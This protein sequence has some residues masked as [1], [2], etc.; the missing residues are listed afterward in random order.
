MMCTQRGHL[1]DILKNRMNSQW[2]PSFYEV[3]KP[4]TVKEVEKQMVRKL[5]WDSKVSGTW[6]GTKAAGVQDLAPGSVAAPGALEESQISDCNSATPSPTRAGKAA[7][8]QKTPGY[9]KLLGRIKMQWEMHICGAPRCGHWLGHYQ[10]NRGT[11]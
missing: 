10:K 3:W 4:I 11:S 5:R 2:N 9:F 8:H 6:A 7:R 1:A